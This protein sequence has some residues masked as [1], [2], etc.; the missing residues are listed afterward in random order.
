MMPSDPTELAGA[1]KADTE[2]VTAWALE[3]WPEED[4]P[5]EPFVTS[6]MITIWGVAAA[7]AAILVAV[8]VGYTKFPSPDM[9]VVKIIDHRTISEVVPPTPPVTVTVT[10]RNLDLDFL[11]L[12]HENRWDIVDPA[13]TIRSAHDYCDGLARGE[14]PDALVET[15]S[16]KGP[17]P[18]P[19]AQKLADMITAAY[20]CQR[21][22][23]S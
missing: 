8:V 2:M 18:W 5:D 1:A 20:G 15:I 9:S 17:L 23:S 13:L 12:L 10:P 7:V 6:Q 11:T 22:R 4:E 14:D 3:E 16:K 19:T 21:G